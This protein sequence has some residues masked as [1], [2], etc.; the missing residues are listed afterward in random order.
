MQGP[1]IDSK[2]KIWQP[3]GLLIVWKRWRTRMQR[4][5]LVLLAVAAGGREAHFNAVQLQKL[6]FLVDKEAAQWFDGPIFDFRPC[7]YGPFDEAVYRELDELI[8]RGF[9]QIGHG[10]AYPRYSITPSGYTHG[11]SML[12]GLPSSLRRYLEKAAQW[13]LSVTLA[14][15][16]LAIYRRYPEM[17]VNSVD[18]QLVAPPSAA[19]LSPASSFLAGMA[20]TLD[21]MGDL[22]E[23]QSKP[24]DVSQDFAAAYSDWRAV[25]ND[26]RA[27]MDSAWIPE[28]P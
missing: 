11:S 28:S 5:D 3:W 2:G 15:L 10:G 18:P 25:G 13:V 4:S 22:R 1:R 20:R 8:R 23:R 17:A 24:R 7:Q 9:I 21:L 12:E 6:L 19:P 27:V 16:L 14:Q 26:I